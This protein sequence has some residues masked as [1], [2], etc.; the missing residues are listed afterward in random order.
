MRT[1]KAEP[2][3][4]TASTR[5]GRYATEKTTSRTPAPRQQVELVAEEGAVDHGHDGLRRREGEGPQA[6][7]LAAGEDDCSH[8]P[9]ARIIAPP[10]GAGAPAFLDG[11]GG[12]HYKTAR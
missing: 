1:P 2:S 4:K 11:R 5:S 12:F 9:G 8:G 7:A 3:P 10:A 6:R